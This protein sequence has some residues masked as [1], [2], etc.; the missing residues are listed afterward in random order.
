MN[1]SK[2]PIAF[3]SELERSRNV[4]SFM[5]DHS[6]TLCSSHWGKRSAQMSLFVLTPADPFLEE[7]K[8]DR[9]TSVHAFPLQEVDECLEMDRIGVSECTIDVKQHSL[10]IRWKRNAGSRHWKTSHTPS[11]TRPSRRLPAV[12][13]TTPSE[14]CCSP[15][16]RD[17]DR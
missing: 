16:C 8:V 6:S 11:E 3:K 4:A 5:S 1:L 12:G 17:D 15:T 13:P 2:P 9:I 10:D 7:S 14:Y